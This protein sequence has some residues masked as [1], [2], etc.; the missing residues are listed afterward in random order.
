MMEN[1]SSFSR[2]LANDAKMGA[3]YTDEEHCKMIRRLFRFPKDEEVCVIEPSIGNGK[4]VI[5]ATGAEENSNIKIFGIEIN[6]QVAKETK[7]NPCMEEVIIADFLDGCKITNNAFSFCFANPPYMD[8]DIGD[9]KKVRTERLFLEKVVNYLSQGA[10]L[11]WIIP[12]RIF[13]EPSY[14]RYFVTRFEVLKVYRF[15]PEEYAKW[16]QV[17]IIGKKRE[18]FQGI[19]VEELQEQLQALKE[20][21][22]AEL[23]KQPIADSE[24]ID[25]PPSK[26]CNILKFTT[27][28]FDAESALTVLE[29]LPE[30]FLKSLNRQITI[31]DYALS[32]VG[33]PPTNLKTDSLYLLATAGIGQG[34]T[35]TDGVDLHLQRGVVKVISE[36]KIEENESGLGGVEREITRSQVCMTV[37]QNNG[38]IDTLE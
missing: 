3:Y 11:C 15:W 19:T 29:S 4:A 10:V 8:L 5:A 35:G 36:S 7:K 33:N 9:N 2:T 34:L 23:P 16:Q 37:I 30:D 1:Q 17:V 32:E 22:V 13:T 25:V 20:S 12:H 27:R 14:Y 26:E 6:D 18:K 28:F 24:L 21:A 31:P 38:T